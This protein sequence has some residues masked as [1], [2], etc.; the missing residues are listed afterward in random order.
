MIAEIFCEIIIFVVSLN[1]S[2]ILALTL[3]SVLASKALVKSSNIKIFGCLIKPW[4]TD[5]RCFCPPE[6]LVALGSKT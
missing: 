3:A 5:K 6:R 1:C 2:L 4:A